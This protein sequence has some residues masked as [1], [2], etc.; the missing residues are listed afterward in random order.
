MNIVRSRIKSGVRG[1]EFLNVG[2]RMPLR[3][4]SPEHLPLGGLVPRHENGGD[5]LGDS[6]ERKGALTREGHNASEAGDEAGTREHLAGTGSRRDTCGPRDG[7]SEVI[8]IASGCFAGVE[9]D[10]DARREA[11]R[12]TVARQGSLDG[13]GARD[14]VVGLAE[15]NE[16]AVAPVLDLLAVPPLEF[17][18]QRPVVPSQQRL[19]RGVAH[20]LGQSRRVDDVGEQERADGSSA[21][22]PGGS[23]V[24][25]DG[26]AELVDQAAGGPQLEARARVVSLSRQG[27]REQYAR[28]GGLVRGVDFAPGADALPSAR[29]SPPWCRRDGAPGARATAAAAAGPGVPNLRRQFLQ[30]GDALGRRLLV[31]HRDA[32]GDVHGEEEERGA[33]ERGSPVRRASG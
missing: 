4:S 20:G 22:G 7:R 9:S 31:T 21:L 5:R 16:E 29:R 27:P 24:E 1:H 33:P 12:G 26:D 2:D 23:D 11:V 8:T 32:R 28:L 19:P 10:A 17:G 30:L 6:L 3:S 14:A 25:V 15:G 13:D 18:A